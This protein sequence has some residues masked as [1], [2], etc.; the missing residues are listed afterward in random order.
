MADCLRHELC[1][2]GADEV[3][4][5]FTGNV[6]ARKTMG[7]QT[8]NAPPGLENAEPLGYRL[9]ESKVPSHEH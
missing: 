2:L 9:K 4:V 1:N 6:H 8:L 3:P 5:I 7:L